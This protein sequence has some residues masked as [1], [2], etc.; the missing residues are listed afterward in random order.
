MSSELIVKCRNIQLCTNLC[1]YMV[2]SI[3][4]MFILKFLLRSYSTHYVLF[5][6][7]QIL[8][9]EHNQ[10][11]SILLDWEVKLN[12]GCL[13][14]FFS[15]WE[16]NCKNGIALSPRILLTVPRELDQW[17]WNNGKHA[18]YQNW[19]ILLWKIFLTLCK[20]WNSIVILFAR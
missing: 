7:S 18:I 10:V 8:N 14:N 17:H 9:C 11:I 19:R 12:M 5:K 20:Q 3:I 15:I 6:V 2:K 13:E 1:F 4:M 16:W